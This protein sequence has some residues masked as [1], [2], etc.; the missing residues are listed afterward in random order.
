MWSN[1]LAYSGPGPIELLVILLISIVI[2]GV[3][4]VIIRSIVRN[5]RET[6]K[7]RFEV[8]KLADEVEKNRKE[9]QKG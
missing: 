8:G 7:L 2:F 1:L 5:K 4:I 3:P 6:Q 9:G